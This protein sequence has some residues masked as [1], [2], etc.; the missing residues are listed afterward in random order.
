ME[1]YY[2]YEIPGVKVGVTQDIE[3]RQEEQKNKG[4]LIV[5]GEYTDIYQVSEKELELQ[6]EKGYHVDKHP[7]WY[8]IKVQNKL[9][10]TPEA[11]A[12]HKANNDFRKASIGSTRK[13]T[14]E[15]VIL[16]RELYKNNISLTA[17]DLARQ[18]NVSLFTMTDVIRGNKYSEIPGGME[19]RSA[20]ITCPHCGTQASTTNF[21]RW[22]GD[23]CR[24][25]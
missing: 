21:K 19:I 25:K 11:K 15:Q 1:T 8:T 2:L 24:K 7:Y 3:R 9:S 14:A 23:N 17:A 10:C 12:K 6:A 20:K 18:F 5:L 22:H 13:L 16:I 4:S